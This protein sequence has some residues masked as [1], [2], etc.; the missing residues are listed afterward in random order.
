MSLRMTEGREEVIRV[1]MQ[2]TGEN[3]KAGAIDKAL[4]HYARDYRNKEALVDEL[5][6]EVVEDLSTPELPMWKEIETGVGTE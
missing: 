2:L 5:D 1:V 4:H 6:Y 3:T